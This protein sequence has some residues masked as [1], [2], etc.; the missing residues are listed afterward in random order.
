M[1]ELELKEKLE[2]QILAKGKE[3]TELRG[4]VFLQYPLCSGICRRN[5]S[6]APRR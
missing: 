2:W 5:R 1:K 4:S 6:T 3:N